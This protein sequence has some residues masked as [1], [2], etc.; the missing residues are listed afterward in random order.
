MDRLE[1]GS[2]NTVR[3]YIHVVTH[4]CVFICVNSIFTFP[5]DVHWTVFESVFSF[6]SPPFSFAFLP[7]L[8]PSL[9]LF[10]PSP[11]SSLSSLPL[12]PPSPPSLPLLPP[13]LPSL[14][15]LTSLSS[16][17]SFPFSPPSLSPRY[18]Q[19]GKPRC[20]WGTMMIWCWQCMTTGWQRDSG[21]WAVNSEL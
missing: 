14:T 12:F 16:L 10:P 20:Y 4:T 1:K 11:P 2:G 13:S 3:W 15:S 19:K 7:L 8:P 9:P 21:W 18:Y 6:L 17:S 5:V